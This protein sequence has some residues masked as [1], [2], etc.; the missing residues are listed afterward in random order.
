[1]T[2]SDLNSTNLLSAPLTTGVRA[3]VKFNRP[4]IE[5]LGYRNTGKQFRL[6]HGAKNYN[7]QFYKVY[8]ARLDAMKPRI[9]E[10][11]K[12][13]L[14]ENILVKNLVDLK[15]DDDGLR[16]EDILIVGTVFKQQERKPS[17]LAELSEDGGLEM[18]PVHT[19]YTSETDSL[20]LEDESMR[21]KLEGGDV[22]KAGDLVNGV[23]VG[24]WG[25][26]VT[27]GKFSVAEVIFAKIEAGEGTP[28][29][30]DIAVCVLSGLELGGECAGWLNAA[31]LATDW[32]IGSVGGPGEQGDIA[33]VERVVVAGD[34]LSMSTRD[35]QDQ[36]KAKYLTANTAAASIAAVRQLDD[37]LV[38]LAGNVNTDIMPGPNDPATMVL[39]QQPLHRVMFPQ[40]GLFPTLQSVTN[41]YSMQ[42]A[43]RNFLVVSG[44]T[45]TDI[46]R[47]STLLGPLEAMAKCLEWAHVAPTAPDTLGCYPYT[48][49]D[50]HILTSLPDV[51][52]A[53]NQDR[54]GAKKV[55]LSGHSVLL[56]SVPKFS[57]TTSLVKINLKSLTCQLLSFGADMDPEW[58]D[59]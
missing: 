52:V 54:F 33:R 41:P 9:I 45:I 39:P 23:V 6:E 13:K 12:E 22:L 29:E 46:L 4:N 15:E 40:A 27:G 14:G 7:R 18:Q 37:L 38:Q 3:E 57:A 24:I 2:L 56:V 36:A 20:V 26:E 42:V 25:R 21:V 34:S 8:G 32:V 48:E 19:V 10:A 43:G 55:V 53:G 5:N 49:E 16:E 1:M 28:T 35:K 11:A 47:N 31:Q 58:I 30:E 44:Q 59:R 51:F 50:P 17:I